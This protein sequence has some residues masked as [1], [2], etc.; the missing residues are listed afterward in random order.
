MAAEQDDDLL[1]NW[2][3]IDE[4][5]AVLEER[6]ERLAIKNSQIESTM[7]STHVVTCEDSSRTPFTPQEPKIMIL[8]RPQEKTDTSPNGMIT[9]K[10]KQPVKTLEQRQQEYAEARLRILG[11]AGSTEEN[12]P[13]PIQ[14]KSLEQR[15]ADYAAARLRIMGS[16]SKSVEEPMLTGNS[17][18]NNMVN[19]QREPQS[20]VGVVRSPKGPDGTCG[21]SRGGG[22][23]R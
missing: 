15:E 7:H 8:R 19:I 9:I 6:L 4:N 3:D 22:H 2:E 21:F 17:P 16:T 18:G 13:K 14:Q 1:D 10:Q 23:H 11:D 12:K 20:N 5:S